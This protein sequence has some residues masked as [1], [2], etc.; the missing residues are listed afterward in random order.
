M[1]DRVF[2]AACVLDVRAQQL[3]VEQVGDSQAAA[4]HFV[5]VG[6]ADAARSGADLDAARSVFRPQF[7]HAMVGKNHLRAIRNKEVAVDF[8]ARGAQGRDFL[9]KAIGSMTTPL[10]MTLVHSGRRIPPGTSCRMNFLP[11]M[12]TVCPALWPPA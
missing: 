7:H 5:F 6:R 3:R 1:R 12:M 2:F 9:Q 11:L 4:S 8:H 10:P